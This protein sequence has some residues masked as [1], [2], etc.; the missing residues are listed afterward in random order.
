MN[1]AA[2]W[3]FVVKASVLLLAVSYDIYTR[4]KSGLGACATSLE[5]ARGLL[6]V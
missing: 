6:V 1:I 4:R 5:K 3:Q 2:H